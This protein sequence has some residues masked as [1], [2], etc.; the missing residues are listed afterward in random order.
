VRLFLAR[1]TVSGPS[2]AHTVVRVR[3]AQAGFLSRVLLLNVPDDL[4]SRVGPGLTTVP[5]TPRTVHTI[6]VRLPNPL[7]AAAIA[8]LLLTG[9]DTSL[10]SMT[11]IT[12]VDKDGTTVAIDRDSRINI[13]EAPGPR[14]LYAVPPRA[15]PLLRAAV[16]LRRRTPRT[17][18]NHGLF[19]NCFGTTPRFEALIAD[20][21]LP[22]PALV[23][24]RLEVG[25]HTAARCWHLRTPVPPAPE[26]LPR[27]GELHP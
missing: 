12:S 5:L 25:W 15:R 17:A 23:H 13:G 21:G 14:H 18:D 1:L 7:R 4:T 24:P 11:Q 22:V 26:I 9:T 2:T 10:L 3:G 19:A 16:A 20:A 27:F 8:A 6:T